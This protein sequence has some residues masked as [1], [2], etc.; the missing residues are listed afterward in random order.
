MGIENENSPIRNAKIP[1]ETYA[2]LKS[3]ANKHG[4]QIRALVALFIEEGL[5]ARKGKR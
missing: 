2:K 5:K 3:Y 1:A 4:Y